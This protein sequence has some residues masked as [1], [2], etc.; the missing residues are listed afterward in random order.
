M[1]CTEVCDSLPYN[2]AMLTDVRVDPAGCFGILG[3]T[4]SDAT[5]IAWCQQHRGEK[6]TVWVPACHPHKRGIHDRVS[7]H[8][9]NP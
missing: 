6:E 8:G 9:W 4:R 3:A 5:S 7:V 2:V 1:E